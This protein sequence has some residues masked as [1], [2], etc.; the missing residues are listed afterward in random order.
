MYKQFIFAL[1]AALFLGGIFFYLKWSKK[2]LPT[3][4]IRA[5]ITSLD[6]TKKALQN[7]GA[8]FKSEYA[9]TDYIYQPKDR[10]VDLNKE[11]I[12][13]RAYEKTGWKQKNF[14][15]AHKIKETTGMTGKTPLYKEF[16][17][18]AEAQQEL[19]DAYTLDFS[20]YRKGWEYAL[21]N[22]KI[23]VEDIQ[24]LSPTIEVV[25]PDK[26]QIENL[27]SKLP[28]TGLITDS[29]PRLIEGKKRAKINP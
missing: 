26:D 19:K 9:F 27:F 1:L 25:A 21:E 14:V 7:L 11:F 8:T 4:E 16:D 13:L 24:G 18:Q 3:A 28:I 6:D 23:F 29:V 2:Q 17:T 20:F 10:K 5:Y 15:L 22:M 12:R